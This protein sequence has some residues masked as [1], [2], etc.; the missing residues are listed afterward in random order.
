MHRRWPRLLLSLMFIALWGVACGDEEP[1]PTNK[2]PVV[3]GPTAQA[4]DV[5]SGTSVA[6]T[7]EASDP[8]GDSL[9]YAW[10]QTPASPAGTFGD[11]SS[12]STTWKAPQVTAAINFQLTLAVSDGKDNIVRRSVTVLVR[13][14]AAANQPPVITTG[15]PTA[16]PSSV[17]GVVLVQLSVTATDPNSDSLTYSWTQEPASPVGS[18]SSATVARPTWS[19]PTVTTA[20]HFTLKVTV[21]DGKG[22]TVQGQVGV[23]VAPPQATNNSPVLSSGPSTSAATINSQQF[24][25]LS[26]SASDPDGDT[27][28]YSWSQ[29][30]ASPVGT[31]S[32]STVTNPKWT[33]PAVTTDTTFQL[34]VIVSDGKGGTVGGSVAVTVIAPANRPPTIS[35]APQ[36]SPTSVTGSAPV[37][38]SVAA[39]DPDGDTLTYAWT[40]TPTSPAGTFNNA[41]AANPTWTSPTV[42][43]TQRFT[44]KVTISDGRGGTVS[45]TVD[46]D[47]AP[48]IPTNNPPT[49]TQ[50]T[51]TPSTLNAMQA[52]TLAVTASDPDGDP[53]TYAWTQQPTT[54]AG[55][56]SSTTT[57]NPTWTAPRAAA[58]TVFQLRVTVSDGKGGTANKAV[59]VTVNAFVNTPPTL[60]AGPSASATTINEQTSVNLS[61]SATDADGDPLT[62]AWTQVS[63]ASPV[64]S[65]SSSS[66]ANPS[67]TAPDVNANTTYRL[68]VTV[69]DGQGGNTQGTVDITVQKVNRPPTVAAT[70]TGPT[71]LLAGDTGTFSLTASDPDGDPLTW[72]WSQTDPTTP[73]EPS[74]A[75]PP[76]RARSGTRPH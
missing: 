34:R 12:A 32:S 14:P 5:S 25:N 64:G 63:P 44:L 65:F 50:P 29:S 69:S 13:P 39:S 16:S 15:T 27:L 18:F 28:T 9:T 52:T 41:S 43:S 70:I 8:E 33:A 6:L 19:S 67:W 4:A 74:W 20:T 24:V 23:D 7:A 59:P 49:L 55:V 37:Q 62:Y 68:R 38:L 76:P 54:P 60:T 1:A 40:Q 47:V 3:T 35:Q 36:A 31:F 72:S 75:R 21:S 10:T 61:V 26:V 58:Q 48:P 57:A 2:V 51:A 45:G 53:I 66:V 73:R 71:T 22:G 46:V 11:A 56:F 30:P 17:T 42:A